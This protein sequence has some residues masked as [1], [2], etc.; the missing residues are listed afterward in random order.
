[1]G[2]ISA[3]SYGDLKLIL[4]SDGTISIW[5]RPSGPPTVG[6][7]FL[8]TMMLTLSML[9]LLDGCFEIGFVQDTMVLAIGASGF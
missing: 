6:Q 8:I 9:R 3:L 4:P 1:M 5:R 2:S 7:T